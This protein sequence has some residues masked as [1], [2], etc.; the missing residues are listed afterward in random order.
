MK[1][2]MSLTLGALKDELPLRRPV[3]ATVDPS[4]T[5]A[6][7]GCDSEAAVEKASAEVDEPIRRPRMV[8][9]ALAEAEAWF[10]H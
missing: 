3:A 6:V 1:G 9:A 7:V 4:S 5:V 10:A 2:K 8:A